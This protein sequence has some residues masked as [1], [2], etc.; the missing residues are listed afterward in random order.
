MNFAW[1]AKNSFMFEQEMDP[2]FKTVRHRNT[3]FSTLFTFLPHVSFSHIFFFFYL[4]RNILCRMQSKELYSFPI[5]L[6]LL[7]L[8]F[9]SLV[10]IAK[11]DSMK[12]GK[13]SSSRLIPYTFDYKSVSNSWKDDF[14]YSG[15]KRYKLPRD[16]L[17][18]AILSLKMRDRSEG[19]PTN[20]ITPNTFLQKRLKTPKGMWDT[21]KS[22][23]TLDVP[24][25]R[26]EFQQECHDE[27]DI[28]VFPVNSRVTSVSKM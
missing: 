20:V 12:G 16:Q 5:L 10:F 1:K 25:D 18:W 22:K 17:V 3:P 2:E 28:V 9:A 26:I 24:W 14:S 23:C 19:E 27:E 7:T 11:H 21:M 6:L 8:S 15:E 13:S 4:W